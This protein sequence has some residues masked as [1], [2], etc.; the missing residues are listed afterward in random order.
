MNGASVVGARSSEGDGVRMAGS[1]AN[2]GLATGVVTDDLIEPEHHNRVAD[3]LD[4]VLGWFLKRMMADGAYSGWT[5]TTA[6]T[7]EPGSGAGERVL[8]DDGEWRRW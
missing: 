4:R 1:T 8:G 7:V 5:L 2:Y 6:G 3:T